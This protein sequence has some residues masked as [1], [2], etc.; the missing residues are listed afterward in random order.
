MAVQTSESDF[1]T[2]FRLSVYR[3]RFK[4][5]FFDPDSNFPAIC[6]CTATASD[7]ASATEGKDLKPGFVKEDRRLALKTGMFRDTSNKFRERVN[8]GMVRLR[9]GYGGQPSR[10]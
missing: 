1:K 9:Q 8:T 5:G 3:R 2:V 6:Y 4:I 10:I 7:T